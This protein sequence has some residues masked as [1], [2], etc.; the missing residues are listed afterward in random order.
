MLC[1]IQR[2]NVRILFKNK[3]RGNGFRL[4]N[5]CCRC[6]TVLQ[7]LPLLETTRLRLDCKK[8]HK[9]SQRIKVKKKINHCGFLAQHPESLCCQCITWSQ[10]KKKIYTCQFVWN[11]GVK[12]MFFLVYFSLF[13]FIKKTY[14]WYSFAVKCNSLLHSALLFTPSH[15]ALN[16]NIEHIPTS[17]VG[18]NP[19]CRVNYSTDRF[20]SVLL[21]THCRTGGLFNNPLTVESRRW[22]AR[23]RPRPVPLSPSSPA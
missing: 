14:N 17:L 2:R 5:P 4:R 20:G 18:V 8:T 23:V 22:P 7:C 15:Y 11:T 9:N 12:K 1:G 3:Y 21:C 6:Q 16:V 19:P 13:S 10:A